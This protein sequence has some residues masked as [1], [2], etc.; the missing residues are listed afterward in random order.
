MIMLMRYTYVLYSPEFIQWYVGYSSNL[1]KRLE[2]H[3]TGKVKSTKHF[4][5][6]TLAYYEA[7]TDINLAQ[8]REHKLKHHGKSFSELKKRITVS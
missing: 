6:W 5:P 1:R 4:I 2:T 3:N 7:Y 8:D